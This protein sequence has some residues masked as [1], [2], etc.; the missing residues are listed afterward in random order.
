M[1]TK[2]VTLQVEVTYDDSLIE[3]DG[4]DGLTG[5]FDTTL[6]VGINECPWPFEAAKWPEIG[7]FHIAKE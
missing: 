3:V 2:T 7:K 1:A 4:Y 6:G 5:V